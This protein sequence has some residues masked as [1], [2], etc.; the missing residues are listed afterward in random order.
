MLCARSTAPLS[1]LNVAVRLRSAP[2]VRLAAARIASSSAVMRI[3]RSMPLSLA[4]WSRTI[5]RFAS[6]SVYLL[7]LR[8]QARPVDQAVA[9]F[10]GSPV[11]FETDRAIGALVRFQQLALEL[12][13]TV[14]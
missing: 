13:A 8:H 7:E 5:P 12:L 10:R 2:N 4:T 6:I 9:D 11:D 14:Q 3:W 1:G